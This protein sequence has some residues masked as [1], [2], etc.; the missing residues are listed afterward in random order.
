VVLRDL[1]LAR[2]AGAVALGLV[3]SAAAMAQDTTPSVSVELNKLEPAGK[4][5]RAY[6]V[7]ENTSESVFASFKLDLIMFGTDGVIARRNALELG[8][9]RAKKK[10]VKTFDLDQPPCEGIGSVLINDVIECSVDG[11]VVTDCLD[12]LTATS[13][14]E[15]QLS[16]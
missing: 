14:T 8:P 15:A 13:R 4:G 6:L 11:A 5:C 10:A 12:R 1:T 7:I 9:L 16:K 2:A 3:M